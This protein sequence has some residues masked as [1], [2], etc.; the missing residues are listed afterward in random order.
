MSH[1]YVRGDI[2]RFRN[3]WGV[4]RSA[5]FDLGPM[6]D[7]WVGQYAA[8]RAEQWYPQRCIYADLSAPFAFDYAGIPPQVVARSM[9]LILTEGTT[10]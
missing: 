8:E 2:V 4:V 3:I 10:S 5:G 6:V 1:D 7:W 9:Q